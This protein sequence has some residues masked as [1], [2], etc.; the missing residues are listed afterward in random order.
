[1]NPLRIKSMTEYRNRLRSEYDEDLL[2]Y[3][4][5]D[6]ENYD[7]L[8][9]RLLL[10]CQLDIRDQNARILKALEFGNEK[11]RAIEWERKHKL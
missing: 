4:E 7:A 3:A 9:V 8:V 2:Y 1:V 5:N 10:E 11:L 6:K